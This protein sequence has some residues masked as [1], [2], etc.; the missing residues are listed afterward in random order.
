M[1]PILTGALT[2]STPESEAATHGKEVLSVEYQLESTLLRDAIST[3]N[4]CSELIAC[5][6]KAL[7]IPLMTSTTLPIRTTL[8]GDRDETMRAFGSAKKM[9]INR[10]QAGLADKID[11][12]PDEYVLSDDE[13][14]LARKVLV[15]EKGSTAAED[16]SN[17]GTLLH[18]FGKVMGRLQDVADGW[19][20]L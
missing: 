9:T 16:V 10:L 13:Y 12:L 3:V 5:Y 19:S 15:H 11:D 14:H 2:E 17:I 18:D 6:R 1:L 20:V 8:E 4:S 7:A